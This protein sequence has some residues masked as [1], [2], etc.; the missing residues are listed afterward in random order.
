MLDA[1][2]LAVN[3]ERRAGALVKVDMGAREGDEG[4]G[5]LKLGEGDE[6]ILGLIGAERVIVPR[7]LSTARLDEPGQNPRPNDAVRPAP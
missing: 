3:E 2:H 1:R 6:G 4:V 7:H 5:R